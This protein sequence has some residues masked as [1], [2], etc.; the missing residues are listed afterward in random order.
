MTRKTFSLITTVLSL[1]IAETVCAGITDSQPYEDTAA[2]HS[3]SL[4][5]IR[6]DLDL[7]GLRRRIFEL[8]IQASALKNDKTP[9][10]EDEAKHLGT[11]RDLS[12]F[13]Y[14][15]LM[16]ALGQNGREAEILKS[17]LSL[18]DGIYDDFQKESKAVIEERKLLD[19]ERA[20][21]SAHSKSLKQKGSEISLST[22]RIEELKTAVDTQK[23]DLVE[24]VKTPPEAR[25]DKFHAKISH[26]AEQVTQLE[27]TLKQL[28]QELDTVCEKEIEPFAQAL[29][30]LNKKLDDFFKREENFNNRVQ[31]LT[32]NFQRRL[33]SALLGHPG[34][35]TTDGDNQT[36]SSAEDWDVLLANV[37]SPSESSIQS[38]KDTPG[39]NEEFNASDTPHPSQEL[40]KDAA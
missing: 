22:S 5:S 38:D 6:P 35:D 32:C 36:A 39:N 3:A 21:L 29:P 15:I 13:R 28:A 8:T 30:E 26:A 12:I 11:E 24:L 16:T 18:V 40:K 7:D 23:K 37:T 25:D 17:K 19:Q 27:N 34:A 9:E 1:S 10:S 14:A 20:A 31:A 2:S 33:C 4:S